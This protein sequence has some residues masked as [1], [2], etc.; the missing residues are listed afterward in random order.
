[1]FTC[2]NVYPLKK[3]GNKSI[4]NRML[5]T[6]FLHFYIISETFSWQTVGCFQ[7]GCVHHRFTQI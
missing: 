2:D 5:R 7:N 6:P 1:M 4:K 3:E